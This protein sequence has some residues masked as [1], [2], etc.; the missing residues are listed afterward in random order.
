[1]TE[2]EVAGPANG[3]SVH[4]AGGVP[5]DMRRSPFEVIHEGGRV[6][7]GSPREKRERGTKVPGVCL[8]SGFN[9]CD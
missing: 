8:F 1:M 3:V 6:R 5:S 4:S 7:S 2:K 9:P